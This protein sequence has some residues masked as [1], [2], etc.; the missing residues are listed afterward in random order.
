MSCLNQEELYS[1][2]LIT[3]LLNIVFISGR[4]NEVSVTKQPN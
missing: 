2:V 3:K 4:V 1:G